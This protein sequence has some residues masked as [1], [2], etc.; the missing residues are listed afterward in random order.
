MLD[1]NGTFRDDSFTQFF[2]PTSAIPPFFQ[3][4][5]PGFLTILGPNPSFHQVA[6]NATFAFAHEAPVYVPETDEV[7]F[8]SSD[9]GPLGNSGLNSNNQVGKINMQAVNAAFATLRPGDTSR[10]FQIPIV[11][12]SGIQFTEAFARGAALS[13][14]VAA[15]WGFRDRYNLDGHEWIF[16]RSSL[17]LAPMPACSSQH[18][19]DDEWGH[20]AIQGFHSS[21]HLW[22]RAAAALDCACEPEGAE[23]CHGVA[24]QFL[25]AAVQLA[26]RHKNSS[27][28]R[29][30]FFH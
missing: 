26:K 30:I 14:V 1:P 16:V 9:G 2:N 22:A 20:G 18:D 27:D 17:L 24:E 12:V 10:S 6:S 11:E 15:E 5:D 8:A 23:Q 29:R 13:N 28:D 25:R 7:F 4:F 21:H 19:P 3:I